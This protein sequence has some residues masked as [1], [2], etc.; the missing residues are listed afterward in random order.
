MP[1]QTNTKKAN[2]LWPLSSIQ[3]IT[4]TDMMRPSVMKF[5]I[6]MITG[7]RSVVWQTI[8]G[9][10]EFRAKATWPSAAGAYPPCG[11]HGNRVRRSLLSSRKR[12]EPTRTPPL[13]LPEHQIASR[14]A[15]AQA[16]LR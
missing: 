7:D 12:Q 6:L 14:V 1:A 8:V 3:K 16:L 2:L 4:G 13:L 9:A 5:G 15:Q 11:A 10:K